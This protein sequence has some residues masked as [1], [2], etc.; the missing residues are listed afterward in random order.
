M[1]KPFVRHL[2]IAGGSLAELETQLLLAKN[3]NFVDS[4]K[5]D[6]CMVQALEVRRMIL[7][8]QKSLKRRLP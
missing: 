5:A 6:A 4:E 7:G 8:L 3:L 2:Q 1:T